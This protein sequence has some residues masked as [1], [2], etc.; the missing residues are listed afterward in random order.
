MQNSSIT[1]TEALYELADS[2][3]IAVFGCRLPECRAV[4]LLSD[5]GQYC[6]GLDVSRR[7]SAAEEKTMLAHELGHCRTGALYDS[8][9]PPEL[10]RRY[11]RR[12]DEWA[13]RN[14]LP[15][16]AI[17]SA[18]KAGLSGSY[19]LAEYFGVEESMMKRAIEYYLRE[20]AWKK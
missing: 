4:S 2:A 9:T 18:C 19:E 13:I 7:Y 10:R 14:C 1:E 17:L 11:E 12:A 15:P 6:I 16:D 5:S 8:L 3:G 20:D